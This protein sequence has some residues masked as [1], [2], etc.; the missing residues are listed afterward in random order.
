MSL[1][2]KMDKK[3]SAL[4][5][6][7]WLFLALFF[8]LAGAGAAWYFF[9]KPAQNA[10]AET[11]PS[12]QTST[13]RVGNISL[14]ISGSGSLIASQSVD[15]SFSTSGSLVEL[16]VKL[17]DTV[18]AGQVLARLGNS[19]SLQA[20]VS[21]ARLDLLQAQND[22]E[23]LQQSAGVSLAQAYQDWVLAKASYEQA[24]TQSQRMDYSRCSQ[25]V[26]TQ[27]AAQLQRASDRLNSLTVGSDAWISAK[28]TYDTALANYTYCAGYTDEEKLEAS[29]EQDLASATLAQA[30][31]KYS[32]LSSGSGI[33]P[34]ELLLAQ[35]KVDQAQTRLTLAEQEL[36][37]IT[38]TSPISGVVTYLSG[39]QG[40]IVGTSKFITISDVS[41]PDVTVYVEEADIEQFVAGHQ[42]EVV[43][44]ALPNQL[45][46]GTLTQVNPELSSSFGT[47]VVQGLVELDPESSTIL[48]TLPLG[49]NA[50]VK[51]ISAEATNVLIVPVEAL[52]DLGDGQYAVFVVGSDGQLAMKMVEV[53]IKDST[54]VEITSGLTQGEV[55]STGLVPTSNQ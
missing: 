1:P 27:K 13:A 46:T 29:A 31:A 49:L 15:L 7:K 40:M 47:T 5:R 12:Y 10:N 36:E 18:T 8:L 39:S 41:Q 2:K 28:G 25:D 6:R 32:T 4:R 43:F 11:S 23:N 52:R 22:L 17:G 35:T 44:D 20:N 51:I 19:V 55:V 48:Q 53:G 33:D 21:S 38:L 45:F 30:E 26:N 34:N 50:S 54:N 16:D 9:L 14:S 42:A 37:G 24:S 3:R